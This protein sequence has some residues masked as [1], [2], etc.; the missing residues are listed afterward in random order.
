MLVRSLIYGLLG[1]ALEIIWTALPT[2]RPVDWQFKGYTF[3]WMFPI[4]ALVGPLYEPVHERLRLAP[5][6]LRALV[7]TAG[8]LAVEATTGLLLRRLLGRCPWDYTGR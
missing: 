3:L 4:Y 8:F 5:W 6:P 1:W 2:R 7:Y